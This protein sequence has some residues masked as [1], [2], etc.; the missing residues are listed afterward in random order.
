MTAES[1]NLPFLWNSLAHQNWGSSRMQ[2][3]RL[4]FVPSYERSEIFTK[5]GEVFAQYSIRSYAL[6]EVFGAWDLL[7]R[8]WAPD[9]VQAEE[10]E[11]AFH[12]VLGQHSLDASEYMHVALAPRHWMWH[13]EPPRAGTLTEPDRHVVDFVDA[14]NSAYCR[15]LDDFVEIGAPPRPDGK[16]SDE[17]RA[18]LSEL[19][20]Q[21]WI[22]QFN[23]ESP[24]VKFFISYG[25]P[26]RA[27]KPSERESALKRIVAT[28]DRVVIEAESYAQTSPEVSI[29]AGSG[30]MT[31]FLILAK[32]PEQHFYKF[33]RRLVFGLNDETDLD[34]LYGSRPYTHVLAHRRFMS[35][36][37]TLDIESS[38]RDLTA[39]DLIRQQESE[40]LEFKASLAADV[41]QY[42]TTGRW[43]RFDAGADA[44]VKAVCGLLNAPDGGVLLIGVQELDRLRGP[45]DRIEAFVDEFG[46]DES[47]EKVVLG[48]MP[49]LNIIPNLKDW[50]SYR[51]HIAQLVANKI[52]PKP[53]PYLTISPE[54]VGGRTVTVIRVRP[55]SSSWFFARSKNDHVRFYARE[56]GRTVEYSGHDI[57][58]YQR[59]HPRRQ[60][61]EHA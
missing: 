61:D 12:R 20:E 42:V 10:L 25:Q 18:E 23:P 17:T 29:Y 49:D 51:L 56:I 47:G 6:Y 45:A 57:G 50:D 1:D 54:E 26:R 30:T 39:E 55:A 5:I 8:L 28:C 14:W 48:M 46:T 3:W 27:L 32:A 59:A 41:Q 40:R 37:E 44:V 15:D 60:W 2:F 24:G 35:F 58:E 4:S 21:G 36:R 11:S 7:I 34:L 9:R 19:L 53:A 43:N 33:A 13:G 22:K 52:D 38:V 31:N 16:T